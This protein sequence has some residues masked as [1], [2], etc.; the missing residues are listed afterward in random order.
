MPDKQFDNLGSVGGMSGQ[1]LRWSQW[2]VDHRAQARRVAVGLFIAVDAILIGIGVWGF[3]DWLAFGGFQEELAIR[4]MTSAGY[5]AGQSPVLE[6]VRIGAPI[7]LQGG[8]GKIDIL[9][10]VENLN[11]RHWAELRYRLVVGGSELP[12]QSAFILPGQASYLTTLSVS[13]EK[14]AGVEVKVEK[15]LWHRATS[16]GG[17]DLQ[18]FAATRLN[19]AGENAV[20]KPADPQAPTA[21]SGASFVLANHTAFNYYDVGVRVLLY[22]GDAVVGIN[23]VRVDRLQAGER[24]PMEIF[25]YQALPQITKVEVVPVINIYDPSAYGKPG[26]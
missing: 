19:I 13:T 5:G 17:L 10:P 7:V 16:A 11:A 15:R 18:A 1:E 4:Q 25:W 24:K 9:V 20:F 12:A 26:N 8:I 6:E 14:G 2:W 21:A 22:R 3:T 23:E